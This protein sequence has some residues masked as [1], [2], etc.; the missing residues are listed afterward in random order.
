MVR[1]GLLAEDMT[2]TDAVQL[3]KVAVRKQRLKVEREVLGI[4]DYQ[5]IHT[6]VSSMKIA[7]FVFRALCVKQIARQSA[8][9]ACCP[10]GSGTA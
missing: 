9:L 3:Q 2:W 7:R 1:F 10:K 8:W 5:R 6:A 4:L